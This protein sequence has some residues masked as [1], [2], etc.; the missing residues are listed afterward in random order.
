MTRVERVEGRQRL[1]RL[2]W[3]SRGEPAGLSRASLVDLPA[4]GLVGARE[5]LLLTAEA[6]A[7]LDRPKRRAELVALPVHSPSLLGGEHERR[8]IPTAFVFPRGLAPRPPSCARVSKTPAPR[9]A[10]FPHCGAARCA[11]LTHA[12]SR[13]AGSPAVSPPAA[14]APRTVPGSAAPLLVDSPEARHGGTRC[15]L[16][17]TLHT[18]RGC[19][20][21]VERDA[22]RRGAARG[23][24]SSKSLSDVRGW[25]LS[26]HRPCRAVVELCRCGPVL[27]VWGLAWGGA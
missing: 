21:E 5:V 3:R 13:A 23:S 18:T 26:G 4:A 9:P 10:C 27:H 15:G 6:P 17:A 2:P 22:A 16:G 24:G 7:P 19:T 14:L 8:G 25:R 20:R 11:R 12:P 1:C